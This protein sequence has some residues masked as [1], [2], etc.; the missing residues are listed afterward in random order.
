MST[1][2]NEH[3]QAKIEAF[4]TC[5]PWTFFQA[6]KLALLCAESDGVY[7]DGAL[8]ACCHLFDEKDFAVIIN[9]RLE[10]FHSRADFKNWVKGTQNWKV[11]NL[12]GGF[13]EYHLRL[14]AAIGTG[15]YIET[16]YLSEFDYEEKLALFALQNSHVHKRR[17]REYLPRDQRDA[18]PVRK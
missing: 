14:I 12:T 7:L 8:D 16:F 15:D 6:R 5:G 11:K 13:K 3:L 4:V 10:N 18:S 9:P 2:S 1:D 17:Q